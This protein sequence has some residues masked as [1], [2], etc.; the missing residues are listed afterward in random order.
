MEKHLSRH[1]RH[2]AN[3]ELRRCASAAGYAKRFFLMHLQLEIPFRAELH[4]LTI[5]IAM[6]YV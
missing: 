5:W 2:R 3:L 4:T 1:Q 6:D